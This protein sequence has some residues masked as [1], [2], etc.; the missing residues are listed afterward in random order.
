MPDSSSSNLL[1]LPPLELP[2]LR[3]VN[4]FNSRCLPLLLC[5]DGDAPCGLNAPVED[6]YEVS[7]AKDG[8][9]GARGMRYDGSAA[10]ARGDGKDVLREWVVEMGGDIDATEDGRDGNSC[11]SLSEPPEVFLRVRG[12][13]AWAAAA[14]D[15]TRRAEGTVSIAG[16][17]VFGEAI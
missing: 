17:L 10:G 12:G 9:A 1:Y 6:L 13:R 5:N 14:G 4:L 7:S 15:P 3:D 11:E 2:P 8:G 16:L